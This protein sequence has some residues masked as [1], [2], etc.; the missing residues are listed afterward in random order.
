MKHILIGIVALAFGLSSAAAATFTAAPK[1]DTIADLTNRVVSTAASSTTLYVEVARFSSSRSYWPKTRLARFAAG[2]TATI[3]P[4]CVEPTTIATARWIFDDCFDEQPL[5]LRW[6]GGEPVMLS[7]Y[8]NR[9]T[10]EFIPID[11]MPAWETARDLK[12]E[13]GGGRIFAEYGDW[14]FGNTNTPGSITYYPN[15]QLV[16]WNGPMGDDTFE[17]T[18]A[19]ANIART[20]QG[21]VFHQFNSGTN[22]FG[23]PFVVAS[24]T[25]VPAYTNNIIGAF[26]DA[27][28]EWVGYYRSGNS[29]ENIALWPSWDWAWGYSNYPAAPILLDQV[30]GFNI[31][32][33]SVNTAAGPALYGRGVFG[34]RAY[35]ST[36]TTPIAGGI[37]IVDSSDTKWSRITVSSPN[38][39]SFSFTGEQ[40]TN[41]TFQA[42]ANTHELSDISLWNNREELVGWVGTSQSV[43]NGGV[44]ENSGV[45]R[46]GWSADPATDL[47]GITNRVGSDTGLPV[48]V[49][50]TSIPGGLNTNAVYYIRWG[51]AGGTNFYLCN[52]SGRAINGGA[53]VDITSAG[54]SGTW[55]LE[56]PSAQIFARDVEELQ[57][58]GARMDQSMS[59]VID[60][61]RAQRVLINGAHIWEVGYNQTEARQS[62]KQT[63]RDPNIVAIR[64]EDVNTFNLSG[65]SIV[66]SKG[67][68]GLSTP[69]NHTAIGVLGLNVKDS[70]ISALFDRVNTGIYLDSRCGSLNSDGSGFGSWVS[71]PV[72]AQ[73]DMYGW[74]TPHVPYFNAKTNSQLVA[75]LGAS[76]TNITGDFAIAAKLRVPEM[77]TNGWANGR[78]SAILNLTSVTNTTSYGALVSKSFSLSIWRSPVNNTMNLVGTLGGTNYDP[79]VPSTERTS[80]GVDVTP[81][82]GKDVE[83]L[84][85]RKDATVEL[86]VEGFLRGTTYIGNSTTGNVYAPYVVMGQVG[87]SGQF[88]HSQTPIYGIA[89]HRSSFTKSE[90]NA[91]DP[92]TRHGGTN[93]VFAYDFSGASLA[94]GVKD[95]SGNGHDGVIQQIGS[96]APEFGTTRDLLIT[97]ANIIRTG[98]RSYALTNILDTESVQDIVGGMLI[99]GGNNLSISYND[100][101]GQVTIDGPSNETIQDLIASTLAAGTNVTISY[102]DPSGIIII[103]ASGGGSGGTAT[104]AT[105][106]YVKGVYQSSVN[107]TNNSQINPSVSGTNLTWSIVAGGVG[108]NEIAS[109]AL[110]Y[111]LARTNHTGNLPVSALNSGSG[112]SSTTFW[113]GDG[114]WATPA[115]GSSSNSTVLVNATNTVVNPNFV[116]TDG[117]V[118]LSVASA[119]NVQVNLNTNISVAQ[120]NIG[121]AYVSNAFGVDVGGSGHSNLTAE[122][123]IAGNGTNPVKLVTAPTTNAIAGWIAGLASQIKL[124]SNTVV[125]SNGYLQL[126]N[127]SASGGGGTVTFTTNLLGYIAKS[128]TQVSVSNTTDEAFLLNFDLPANTLNVDGDELEVYVPAKYQMY[129]SQTTTYRWDFYLDYNETPSGVSGDYTSASFP[130]TSSYYSQLWTARIKRMSS[131]TVSMMVTHILGSDAISKATNL[132]EQTQFL[133]NYTMQN[134]GGWASNF[135]FALSVTLGS[136][137]SVHGVNTF[138]YTVH[139]IGSG[140]SGSSTNYISAVTSDFQVNSGTLSLSNTPVTAG[141]YPNATV[142]VDAKGRVTS[143]SSNAVS[144]GITWDID[145]TYVLTNTDTTIYPVL[146]NSV[147][148]GVSRFYELQVAQSGATNGGS[149]KLFAR[150]TN[151]SG[152]ASAT[153]WIDSGG[154]MDT[155]ALAYLTNSG[156]NLLVMARGPLYQPQNGRI[157]GSYLQVTNAGAYASAGVPMT[158]GLLSY[159]AMTNTGSATEPDFFNVHPMVVSAGDTIPTTNN[160][161]LQPARLFNDGEDDYM[162]ATNN[163]FASTDS[164]TV[165]GWF[166]ADSI[167]A[168][169][170]IWGRSQVGNLRM[171]ST[172]STLRMVI[173]NA[174]TNKEIV[175]PVLGMNTNYFFGCIYNVTNGN[176]YLMVCSPTYTNLY[177]TTFAPGVEPSTNDFYISATSSSL[178]ANWA[179]SIDDIWLSKRAMTTN[180]IIQLYNGGTGYPLSSWPNL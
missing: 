74:I 43:T 54:G 39:A 157:R 26:P 154:A 7:G 128:V 76:H 168:T 85:Q 44:I 101:S 21:T 62:R 46:T 81:F 14:R 56:G 24:A 42:T 2:S 134:P 177:S 84:V 45:P 90:I 36:F 57:I 59:G 23:V 37:V 124:G 129:N 91:G 139:K 143:I 132:V 25:R 121:T 165:G 79:A 73:P 106:F 107:A 146:T 149:W 171:A 80:F 112:A 60:I 123:Y 82:I 136:A 115:G 41:G 78:H 164:F 104:N 145:S 34:L 113:R 19:S 22:G 119:T 144:S 94:S 15:V 150:I 86:Y 52:T 6:T 47:I 5:D 96:V 105:A 159:W 98:R 68:T 100:P 138:G 118:V 140:G 55:W 8:T 28:G 77:T 125:D 111:L 151:R 135:N 170:Y 53:V 3:R 32:N 172:D 110:A 109:A 133:Q 163:V 51:T 97:G 66:G 173:A 141:T 142:T 1:V 67:Y 70:Q 179:G 49:R 131:N 65:S 130:Y 178:T 89:M 35:D 29:L 13:L 12:Y 161:P 166:R 174:S 156:T 75:T 4:G 63:F 58:N 31:K 9:I 155:N 180:E 99:S 61:G 117:N 162:V 126:T 95:W 122:A 108:T 17:G 137:N 88:S 92:W 158:N 167:A 147:P 102:D 153:N 69:W 120:A 160:T 116:N 169:R 114:V 93:L 11:S 20:M 127:V 33:V 18:Y 87:D 103:S 83:I 30:A 152:T 40:R 38:G 148:D 50:G 71:R 64:L 72:D 16:G 48:M 10:A 176:A 27:N 175:G